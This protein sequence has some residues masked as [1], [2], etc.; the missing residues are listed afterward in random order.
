MQALN[1]DH[2]R[3]HFPALDSPWAL[4]DNAGGSAPARSVIERVKDHM[5]RLPVQLGASYAASQEAGAAVDAGRAAAARL[6]GAQASEVVLGASSTALLRLLARGLA[7]T[8]SAGDE[9]IV[10]RLDHEANIGAWL[11]LEAQGI[12]VRE[13]PLARESAT[14][15]LEDLEPRHGP[16]TRLVAFTHVTNVVGTIHDVARIAARVRAAGAL[17][18]CDGVA[19]APHRRVDVE[20]LGV[21]LYCASLYKVYGPHVACLWARPEVLR[22]AAGQSHFFVGEDELTRKFEP[23]GVAYEL[24]ASLPGITEYLEAID[25][26]HDG[27]APAQVDPLTRVFERCAR[28]EAQVVDP[29]LAFLREHPAVKLLGEPSSDPLLRVP[30]VTFHV[31]GSH[32][33]RLPLALDAQRVAIRWGDFYAARAIDDL[34][35]AASGGVVRISL[36]HYNAPQEVERL[37]EALDAALAAG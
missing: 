30:T 34:G 14:L 26:L 11:A 7:A 35:L 27:P 8:W 25:I 32:A 10:T 19:F 3:P 12:V 33:S 2:V 9:V 16:R 5:A 36:V 28:H 23:G 15:E 24:V 6:L 1:L 20:A 17:A 37:I 13:W 4:F 31:P 29:L 21:D 22:S 18:C